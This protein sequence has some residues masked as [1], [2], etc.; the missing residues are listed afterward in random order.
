MTGLCDAAVN[1]DAVTPR[2]HSVRQ[3]VT[4]ISF[5]SMNRPS[6]NLSTRWLTALSGRTEPWGRPSS[7]SAQSR[8]ASTLPAS[9][10]EFSAQWLVI[11]LLWSVILPQGQEEASWW[12]LCG[13]NENTSAAASDLLAS[14]KEIN[15]A[16]ALVFRVYAFIFFWEDQ[17]VSA[18]FPFVSTP[19][20]SCGH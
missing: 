14:R 16:I 19:L 15:L 7:H 10:L 13:N 17:V 11:Q 3:L 18:S 20:I 12:T 2:K 9:S 6:E 1:P 5:M 4:S 8:V